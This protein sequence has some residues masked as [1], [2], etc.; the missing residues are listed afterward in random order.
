MRGVGVST[1]GI[2]P[3]RHEPAAAVPPTR[4]EGGGRVPPTRHEPT[5]GVPPTRREPDER[6]PP[7]GDG[8]ASP[9]L[10]TTLP[11]ELAGSR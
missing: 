2:P 4:H 1:P 8:A 6:F 9:D 11:P 3:T 5:A 7:A 10:E